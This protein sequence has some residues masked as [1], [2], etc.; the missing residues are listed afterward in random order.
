MLAERT[1]MS[2][3][4]LTHIKNGT[5]RWNE[6]ILKRLAEAFEIHPVELLQKS[7]GDAQAP[8][9]TEGVRGA[10]LSHELMLGEAPLVV[11]VVGDI[12]SEPSAE[13]NRAMQVATGFKNTYVPVLGLNDP[14]AFC[15]RIDSHLY[16][17][18]FLKGDD[19][20]VSPQASISSGDVVAI[21]YGKGEKTKAF[22]QV[23]YLDDFI[24]LESLSHKK[25]PVALVK[26]KDYYRIIGKVVF[27]YQK[28]D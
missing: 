19:V 25:T 21:E 10:R 5:R 24:I 22:V 13:N 2:E 4:Y 14:D 11:P 8:K 15:V 7:P 20:V 9:A 16:K 28:L 27:R 6:D 18:R 23:S 3:S 17:P 1:G 12:V 26:N